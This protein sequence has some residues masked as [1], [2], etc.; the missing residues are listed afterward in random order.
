MSMPALERPAAL[1]VVFLGTPAFAVPS[2]RACA[3]ATS[4]VSVITQPDRPAGRGRKVTA[5]PVAIAARDLGL[6]VLQPTSLKSESVQ[7]DIDAL[8]PDIIACVAYGRI[9]PVAVLSM[10]RLG[11]INLHPSMLPAYRG[12]S[13]IASA[14]ADGVRTTGVTVMHLAEELDAG[15]IILQREVEIA[16]EETAGELETRLAEIG[17]DMMLEAIEML[18]RGTAPR[19]PQDSSRATYVGK[20]EKAS[21]EIQWERPAR[22]IVNHVRAMNPWPCAF[23]AWRG[24]TLKVWRAR[25]GGGEGMSGTV[26]GVDDDGIMVAAGD[27]AVLLVEVQQEGGRVLAAGAFARGSRLKVGERLG[28]SGAEPDAQA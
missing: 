19:V 23:T 13:P 28:A 5:P 10:P 6:R 15:D 20:I 24:G 18:A 2:L 26:L 14:I 25:V 4:V 21:G 27:G 11:A 22:A 12:A 7:R 1:R 17:A 3:A 8:R 9:I 16:P